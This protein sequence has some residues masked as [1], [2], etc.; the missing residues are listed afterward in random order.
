MY[1]V[2]IEINNKK[3]KK[4]LT[5][6]FSFGGIDTSSYRDQMNEVADYLYEQDFDFDVDEDG[7]M[8]IDDILM[9]ISEQAEFTRSITGKGFV[10]TVRGTRN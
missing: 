7:D 2:R 1:I 8:V 3:S 5:K 6:D 4:L 10:C 9:D